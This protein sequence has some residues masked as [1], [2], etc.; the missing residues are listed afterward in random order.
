MNFKISCSELTNGLLKILSVVDKKNTRS[1]LQ[2]CYFELKKN[3]LNLYATDL[4]ISV[5]VKTETSSSDSGSFCIN[6]KNIYDVVKELPDEVLNLNYEADKKTL[7]L[8]CK[9][10][11]FNLYTTDNEEFP[12]LA[13][14]EI[15][16]DFILNSKS[17]LKIINKTFYATSTDETRINLNGIFFQKIDSKLRCVAI[18]GHRFALIEL[19]Q[20]EFVNSALQDG[21]I[22]PRKGIMELKKISESYPNGDINFSVNESF[23]EASVD[24]KYELSVRLI[25][26]EYPKYQNILPSKTL[27]SITVDK[28]ALYDS[29]KRVRVLSNEKTYGIKFSLS[30]NKLE[31]KSS[32]SA[33]GSAKEEI[34][35]IYKGINIEI[36]FN[37]KYI[38]ETLQ[39]FETQEV[40]FEFNNELSPVLV[41]SVDFPDFL[42]L[43]MPLKL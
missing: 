30:E 32:Q 22:V 4:E 2:S 15:K 40:T 9:S 5:K 27:E 17:I 1:I 8:K 25:A 12:Q 6:A 39:V 35:V 42:A 16:K 29:I 41:K 33:L 23:I 14:K 13:F 20:F 24:G 21:I 34:P 19:N 37:A 7:C 43:I 11:I 18:D 28:T 3:E 10:S 36:G 31:I 38:M 26:R